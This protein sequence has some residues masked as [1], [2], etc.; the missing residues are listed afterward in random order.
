MQRNLRRFTLFLEYFSSYLKQVENRAEQMSITIP[1]YLHYVST[2]WGT[3]KVHF[4]YS[5]AND[6]V[7]LLMQ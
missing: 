5:M 7:G 1:F 2:V 3:L 4:D 6:T